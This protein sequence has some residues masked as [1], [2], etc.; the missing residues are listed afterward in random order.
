M[1]VCVTSL[2]L[3]PVHLMEDIDSVRDRRVHARARTRKH[4]TPTIRYRV[5]MHAMHN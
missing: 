4:D 3:V 5:S 1:S 2:M